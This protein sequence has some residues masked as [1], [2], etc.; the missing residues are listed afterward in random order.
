MLCVKLRLHKLNIYPTNGIV[1]H[2]SKFE[3]M[4]ENKIRLT[5]EKPLWYI[6]ANRCCFIVCVQMNFIFRRCFID[7]IIKSNK[8]QNIF[9]SNPKI[10]QNVWVEKWR[11]KTLFFLLFKNLHQP[12][13]GKKTINWTATRLNIFFLK[14]KEKKNKIKPRW[15]EKIYFPFSFFTCVMVRL[16]KN[17]KRK[18]E[19]EKYNFSNPFIAKETNRNKL[20]LISQ[21]Q[22]TTY[23][24]KF[25]MFFGET[26][27][28]QTEKWILKFW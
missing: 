22:K 15:Q 28:D 5:I 7:N 13:C 27:R 20:Y 18:T 23:S 10:I 2:E 26:T 25:Y 4:D 14:K 8:T 21:P 16:D 24:C 17:R 19:S 6:W 3:W 11:G 9:I 1:F 12:Y